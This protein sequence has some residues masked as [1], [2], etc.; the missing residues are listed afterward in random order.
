[1]PD[2]VGDVAQGELA[3]SLLAR[4]LPRG[5]EDL[6]PRRLTAFGLPIAIRCA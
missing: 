1:M 6:E 4:H 2:P 5:L 3:E